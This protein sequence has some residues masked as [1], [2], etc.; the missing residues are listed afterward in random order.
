MPS[1]NFMILYVDSPPA[2][3]ALYADLLGEPT[4]E[5]SP[6]FADPRAMGD[7]VRYGALVREGGLVAFHDIVDDSRTRGGPPTIA[8]TGDVPNV[9]AQV[10]RSAP[11][12]WEFV[13]DRAQDGCGI[14]VLEVG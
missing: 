4:A 12:T 2:S 1:P 11:K 10:S 6:T 5:T 8:Y 9:W 3:A 13:R 7:Y 14:G